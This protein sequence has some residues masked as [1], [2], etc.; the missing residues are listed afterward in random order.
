MNLL[1]GLWLW[2]VAFQ[3]CPSNCDYAPRNDN[4]D[5]A[6]EFEKMKNVALTWE[7]YIFAS[8]SVIGISI[9]IWLCIKFRSHFCCNGCSCCY[10]KDGTC[11]C[12]RAKKAKNSILAHESIEMESLYSI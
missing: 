3:L 6:N 11:C 10:R 2:L 12:R 8:F 7:H 9:K 4:D 1:L 5:D